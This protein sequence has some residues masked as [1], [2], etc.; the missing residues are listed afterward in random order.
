METLKLELREDATRQGI[1]AQLFALLSDQAI[2][3]I[4]STVAPLA[5]SDGHCHGFPEVVQAIEAQELDAAVRADAVEVYR[6]L[7]GAEA[8]V[9][10]CSPDETHFH[11]VGNHEAIANVLAICLAIHELA[12]QR[13]VAT[14]VQAGRG[15]VQCAHGLLDI[16][17]PATAA[18]LAQ[19]IP[20][21]LEKR[22][23]EWCTPTSAAIIKHFVNEFTE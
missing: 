9:H 10:G 3:G 1:R 18:I 16:P 2:A 15:K 7:N 8:Q 17:A 4:E 5:Q 22:E 11:E 23:G 20:V 6:L 21:A 14:P 13:I 12:P 19:G